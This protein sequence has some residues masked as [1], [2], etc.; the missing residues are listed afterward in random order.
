[1]EKKPIVNTLRQMPVGTTVAF[2]IEQLVSVRSTLIDR[3]IP[4]KR[5]G[6]SWTTAKNEAAGTIEVTRK[7]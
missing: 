1:M 6:Q 5:A 4:E 7:S 3:L 2:P